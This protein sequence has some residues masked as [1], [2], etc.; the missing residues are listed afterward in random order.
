MAMIGREQRMQDRRARARRADHEHRLDDLLVTHPRV[1]A[2]DIA[3]LQA[4][5]EQPQEEP[6]SDPPAQHVEVGLGLE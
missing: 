3:Q 1:A 2:H 5:L 4:H 6:T